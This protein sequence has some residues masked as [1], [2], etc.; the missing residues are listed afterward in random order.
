MCYLLETSFRQMSILAVSLIQ[1]KELFPYLTS[2]KVLSE[3]VG[4]GMNTRLQFTHSYLQG[5]VKVEQN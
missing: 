3:M 5:P 2:F 1:I 4:R